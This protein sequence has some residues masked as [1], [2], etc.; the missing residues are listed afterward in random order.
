MAQTIQQKSEGS[1]RFYLQ[2]AET[3]EK[4]QRIII[5]MSKNSLSKVVGIEWYNTRKD[6]GRSG[7]SKYE[8]FVYAPRLAK[9]LKSRI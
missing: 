8:E 4:T 5:L 3:L 7:D 1:D 6:V 2:G 9:G